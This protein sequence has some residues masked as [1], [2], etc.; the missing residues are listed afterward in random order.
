M[1]HMRHVPTPPAN[2]HAA[3]R[4]IVVET[5]PM[6]TIAPRLVGHERHTRTT[7]PTNRHRCAGRDMR[8][9]RVAASCAQHGRRPSFEK[10]VVGTHIHNIHLELR[11]HMHRIGRATRNAHDGNRRDVAR[12]DRAGDTVSWMT[13][14]GA[15]AFDCRQA[16]DLQQITAAVAASAAHGRQLSAVSLV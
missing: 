14:R 13:M 7:T 9:R 8:C 4:L 11:T 5:N 1:C 16:L 6:L 2:T 15:A 3:Q 12:P 10:A